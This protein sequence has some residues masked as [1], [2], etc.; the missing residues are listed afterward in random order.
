M[1]K[2]IARLHAAAMLCQGDHT[3]AQPL[4]HLLSF[5]EL[6]ACHFAGNDQGTE[7]MVAQCP[8]AGMKVVGKRQWAWQALLAGCGFHEMLC[9]V[10]LN[11]G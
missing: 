11:Q 5:A 7:A 3:L 9:P 10:A 6:L 8:F 4:L 2:H 1:E